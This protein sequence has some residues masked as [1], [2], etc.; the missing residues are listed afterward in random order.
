MTLEKALHNNVT[1][2]RS[3][4]QKDMS[5]KSASSLRYDVDRGKR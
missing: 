1:Q 2:S 3:E 4:H 5:K